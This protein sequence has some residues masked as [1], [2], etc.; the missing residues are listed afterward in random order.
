MI[1]QSN[2]NLYRGYCGGAHLF[3]P[4]VVKPAC[5]DGTSSGRVCVVFLKPSLTEGVLF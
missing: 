3:H 1:A 4:R 2:Y 5:A